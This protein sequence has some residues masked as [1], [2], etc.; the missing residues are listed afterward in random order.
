M[1]PP[2]PPGPDRQCAGE[3]HQAEVVPLDL[4]V[5]MDAS[6]SMGQLAG[7]R[8]KWETAQSALSAFIRDPSSA[9]L[10]MGLQFF[11][12]DVPRPCTTSQDCSMGFTCRVRTACGSP[13]VTM[14]TQVC[15][16]GVIFL[17]PTVCP[18]GTMCVPAG[19]CS[20]SGALCTNIGRA[21]AGAGGTCVASPGTCAST[22]LF[23]STECDPRNYETAAVPIGT[24]PA[25]EMPLL[26]ALNA[27]GPSGG[28]PMGP[29]V[30]GAL[31]QLQARL[32]ANP[33]RKAALVLASDG[34]PS[35][36]PMGSTIADVA[37]LLGPAFMGTPSIPTYVIGVFTMSEL[38]KSQMELDRLAM[39][40][41]SG[42]AFVLEAASDLTQ[43]LQEALNQIR[44]AALA[45]EYQIPPPTG[46]PIDFS[47]VNVRYSG[48]GA[49][50]NIPYVERAD[51]CDPMRGGWYYDVP[52]SM[53]VPT[54]ILTCDATC[55]RFKTDQSGKVELVFGC[56]T[57]VIN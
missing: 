39:A 36:C 7:M 14:P 54:R 25:A 53:G 33:G 45:C 24:L 55:R 47:R 22:S 48:G 17:P 49:S 28:T 51:R 2:A 50:E 41:G 40:G 46:G 31:G 42:K 8:S 26:M 29:A 13:T 38:A 16:T 3:A 4:L 27:H 9:G 34:L 6:S 23:G 56:G 57:Q 37:A 35:A 19:A 15:R 30:R 10:G 52:P 18:A 5:L 44:G 32:A 20:A 21:C 43:R 11:P 1:P 12:N